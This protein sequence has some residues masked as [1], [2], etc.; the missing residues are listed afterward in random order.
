MCVVTVHFGG[1]TP[2]VPD[3]NGGFYNIIE[4]C[5]N[6]HV[7]ASDIHVVAKMPTC[8]VTVHFGGSTPFRF[9][10]HFPKINLHSAFPQLYN[11]V[12]WNLRYNNT[13][14]LEWSH[15]LELYSGETRGN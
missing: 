13:R 4:G 7:W 10:G 1:R 5:Y 6:I 3:A 8:V 2:N 15:Y 12:L 14:Q 9:P 11:M